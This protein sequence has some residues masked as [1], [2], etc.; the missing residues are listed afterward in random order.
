LNENRY[1]EVVGLGGNSVDFL[2]PISR[3]PIPGEKFLLK[4]FEI[5]GG[6]V[7]A[8]C[9][10]Q[11]SR[12]GE[13]VGWL[14]K[15][16]DDKIK[17]LIQEICNRDNINLYEISEKGS[18]STFCWLFI[19][20]TGEMVSYMFPNAALALTPE[21]V[22][23]EFDEIIRKSKILFTDVCQVPLAPIIK[24]MEIAAGAGVLRF[25]DLD[26]LPMAPNSGIGSEREL[27]N[28]FKLA[29]VVFSP[30]NVA[31]AISGESEINRIC[32]FFLNF[33]IDI[34]V[35]TMGSRGCMVSERE[36]ITVEVPTFKVDVVDTI[37]AGD[38]SHGGFIYGFL[39]G[40]DLQ[41]VAMFANAC[42]AF[43]CMGRGARHLANKEEIVDFLEKFGGKSLV[44]LISR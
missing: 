21:E 16:G 15:V 10:A 29:N 37:G 13:K 39:K 5:E 17:S 14:G 8:T 33:G 9:L 6:G 12:L 20:P 44:S 26:T 24:G 42:G 19:D 2:V 23:K 7:T 28:A 41:S 3:F 18:L 35:V 34:V 38:A 4:N 31:K 25:F 43:C 32:R 27:Y 1:P 36:G 22:E 40:W 11:L 30:I